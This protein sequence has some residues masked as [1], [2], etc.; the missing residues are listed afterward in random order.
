MKNHEF[1]AEFLESAEAGLHGGMRLT[2]TVSMPDGD[3]LVSWYKHDWVWTP[4]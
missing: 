4:I 2:Y 1:G 3:Y